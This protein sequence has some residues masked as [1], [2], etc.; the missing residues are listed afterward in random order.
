MCWYTFH[1]IKYNIV[2]KTVTQIPIG[3]NKTLSDKWRYHFIVSNT[4]LSDRWRYIFHWIKCNIADR[5]RYIFH[6]IKYNIVRQ[7]TVQISLDQIQHCPIGGV[8]HFI[9]LEYLYRRV[10]TTH[11]LNAI[12]YPQS[13]ENTVRCIAV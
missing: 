4:T 3:S 1:L 7:V 11:D 13:S 10:A 5:W 8:T 6:W 2:R 12:L 9:V